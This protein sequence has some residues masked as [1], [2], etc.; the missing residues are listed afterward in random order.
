MND[1]LRSILAVTLICSMSVLSSNAQDHLLKVRVIAP[2]S[3]PKNDTLI[4]VG[5]D[6]KIGNWFYPS[7]PRMERE[8]DSTWVYEGYFPNNSFVNFKITRGSYYKEAMYY[9]GDVAPQPFSLIKDTTLVVYPTNWN[10]LYN[11]SIVGTVRY[12]H[13]FEDPHLKNTRDV[14]V[15]LPPSY[16]DLPDRNYP[17]LYA[18]DGQ[19]LMDQSTSYG[20]EWRLD[21]VADSLMRVGEIEEFI[22]VAISNTKDRWVEYSGTPE[23]MDYLNFIV[24]NLKPFID[25]H[26]R[27]KKDQ[28]NTA[29]MGSSMGGLISF[30]MAWLHPDVFSKAAGLS[31]GFAFDDGNIL[32]QVAESNKKLPGTRLYLDCGDQELDNHFLPA[33]DEMDRL[34]VS[35]H[36]EI[37]LK[38]QIFPGAY[39]NEQ[40]WSK[41]LEIP[42][43]F[44]FGK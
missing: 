14:V 27:T 42:L 5:E 21:E 16:E 1:M 13:Q 37:E 9:D 18:H 31:S 15:W 44:L 43:V 7:A 32:K 41:R 4:L 40:A 34:L 36:P 6:N 22:I 11:R 26:Y 38:Y 3:T 28:A 29:M 39:H 23:G 19:N 2:S 17:V 33:N 10:D 25:E 30:Y 24:D 12:H 35:K 8:N 20:R